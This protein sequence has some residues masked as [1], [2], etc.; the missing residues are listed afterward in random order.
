MSQCPQCG[1]NNLE[2]SRFCRSCGATI[3]V[4][5]V[6]PVQQ[7][8]QPVAMQYPQQYGQ[9]APMQPMMNPKMMTFWAI[10]LIAFGAILAGIGAFASTALYG[11]GYILAG[12]G[13][14]MYAMV[15]YQKK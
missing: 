9:P 10:L 12:I 6:A 14:L 4:A 3:A 7:L 8:Q 2:G 11:G 15:Y 5:P 1:A 13:A